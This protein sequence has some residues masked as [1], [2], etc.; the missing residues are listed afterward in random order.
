M[1]KR[2]DLDKNIAL[3]D[4]REFYW[5]KEELLAF[6]RIEGL[7]QSGGKLAVT[8]RIDHYLRTG[9]KLLPARKPATTGKSGFDWQTAE[10]TTATIITDNY[11]NTRN[12]RKFFEEQIGKR[13][14]FNVKFMNWMKSNA[15]KTLHE[16]VAAWLEIEQEKKSGKLP[17]EI[18]PQL[19]YNRYLRDFLADNPGKS[20][21]IGIRLWKIK[22]K[23]RGDNIYRKTDFKLLDSTV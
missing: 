6:C 14:R 11:R 19:E 20:R 18:P 9:E 5:L 7:H 21:D 16:A 22:K 17:K 15:G 12:V 1:D 23:M 4:F 10:L 13:F 8:E 3:K 2:P